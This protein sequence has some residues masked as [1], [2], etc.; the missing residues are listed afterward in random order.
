MVDSF[1]TWF[2]S[3]A[4]NKLSVPTKFV[5]LSLYTILGRPLRAINLLN[6]KR[7][8]LVDSDEISSKW[9]ALYTAQVYKV[10]HVFVPSFRIKGP[11]KSIPQISNTEAS[12]TR[13]SGNAIGGDTTCCAVCRRQTTQEDI[14]LFIVFLPFRIQNFS[15]SCLMTMLT[16]ACDKCICSCIMRR[17]TNRC[18]V[19]R[20]TGHT[21]LSCSP[22]LFIIFVFTRK[23]PS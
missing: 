20:I 6:P 15:L 14:T 5:P 11:A 4:L 17:S 2:Q 18:L 23:T 16:P 10:I 13:S 21:K 3:I 8:P 22:F 7:K 19:G 12:L 1:S 9:T